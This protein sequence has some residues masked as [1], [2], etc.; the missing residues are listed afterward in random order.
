VF[1]FGVGHMMIE[2][3]FA[4][5]GKPFA[6]PLGDVD[7]AADSVARIVA[8]A[9]E[10]ILEEEIAHRDEHS[11]EF[12]ALALRRRF[13][14]A[15]VRIVPLLC[16][17]FHE[18]VRYERRPAD[19]PRIEGPLAAIAAEAARLEADGVRVAHVAAVDFSHVGAR[20]GD[21]LDLDA[22]L[23]A[24]IERQDRA[25]I[26]AALTGDADTWFDAIAAHDDSTRICGFAA[27]Y[28]ML[29]VA[30]PG[31]GRLLGYEQSVEPGG[32][33]VT[34]ASLVWP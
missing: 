12:Q 22:T 34:Y 11:I 26:D 2:E 17:G 32:S 20:F 33:V 18:L 16:S 25:A 21:A 28:A 29:R 27:M 14:A 19:E 7:V 4:I 6:T 31:A 9:G 5:T 3:P 1:V 10:A 13:G 8:A 30:R 15:P 23:L 24:E